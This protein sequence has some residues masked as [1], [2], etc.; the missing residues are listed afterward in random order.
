MAKGKGMKRNQK[1]P[2]MGPSG[3]RKG[4]AGK[5]GTNRATPTAGIGMSGMGHQGYMC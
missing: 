5:R 3:P 2:R 1:K 4:I